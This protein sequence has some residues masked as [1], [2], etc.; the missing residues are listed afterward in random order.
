M[1]LHAGDSITDIKGNKEICYR[2]GGSSSGC[3][4]LQGAAQARESAVRYFYN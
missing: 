4:G 2:A 1:A 3:Q